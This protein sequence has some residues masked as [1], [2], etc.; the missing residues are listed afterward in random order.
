MKGRASKAS[1]QKKATAKAWHGIFWITIITITFSLSALILAA[2]AQNTTNNYP[3]NV[4]GILFALRDLR[5]DIRDLGNRILQTEEKMRA[6]GLL[7]STPSTNTAQT[8]QTTQA[9]QT[10]TQL[11]TQENTT[12]VAV[13]TQ[14]QTIDPNKEANYKICNDQCKA[15]YGSC[16]NAGQK[17]S[18]ATGIT[19]NDPTCDAYYQKECLQLCTDWY[20]YPAPT[21]TPVPPIES[22]GQTCLL[23][24]R[25][26]QLLCLASAGK[27]L[28]KIDFCNSVDKK[29]R[30]TCPVMNEANKY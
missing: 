24:C 25:T 14:T 30:I 28:A 20:F 6:L 17:A 29:C 1:H 2:S 8:E 13:T 18:Y 15:T 21:K 23:K 3:R 12:L 16:L 7:S 22:A 11:K 27:D 10:T 26:D 9:T 5:K 19:G 4:P